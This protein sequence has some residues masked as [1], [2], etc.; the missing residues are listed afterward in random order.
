MKKI[1]VIFLRSAK[2]LLSRKQYS[3]WREIQ[4]DYDDYIA[5]LEFETLI[6]I[7]EHL[8]IDYKI[9]TEKAKREINRLNDSTQDTIEIAL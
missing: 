4:D 1:N 2:I 8:K 9:S 6:E 5:S 7:E 3:D